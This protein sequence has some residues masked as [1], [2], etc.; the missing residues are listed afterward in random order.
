MTSAVDPMTPLRGAARYTGSRVARV[1]DARLL[2]G[3]GVFVDDVVLQGMLHCCFVRSP[4]ARARIVG[5]DVSEAQALPG[6]HAVFVGADLNSMSVLPQPEPTSLYF[7]VDVPWAPL[8]EDCARFVGDPVALVVAQDRYVAEDASDLVVV[9]YEPLPA[10]VDYGEAENTDILVHESIGTNSSGEFG[11]GMDE[12]ETVLSASDHV[13]EHTIHQQAYAAV[14]METRGIVVDYS[15]STGEMTVYAA[16]QSPHEMRA[17]CSR[18]LGMPQHRIRVIMKDT[19]GGFGQKIYAQREE[20]VVILAARKLGTPLKWIEDRQENLISGGKSRIEHGTVRLAFDG[21]GT[22]QGVQLD[23]VSDSGA[24]PRP[25]PMSTV[26]LTGPMFP[27]P[28]RVPAAGFRCRTV[29][30]NTVPRTPYRGPWQFETLARE[31]SYDIAARQLGIDPIELR[32]RNL[33]SRDDMPYANP[34][35]MAYD[36][37]SPLETFEHGLEI[38][39]YEAFRREQA[40]ARAAGRFIGV[41]IGNYVEP[42]TPG[43]GSHGTEGATIRI[44]PTGE[45]NV[46]IAGGSSGNSVETTV[47]QLTAD[48]LGVDIADVNTIQGDTAVTGFGAG[49]G[50]SRTGSMIAGAIGTTASLLRD[51]M[52]AIAAHQLEASIDDIEL[53]DG[54]ASVRGTP[55][56]GMTVREIAEVSYNVSILPP[57]I[58]AGLEV[59]ARYASTVAPFIFVN[60]THICT[61]EVDIETGFVRLLRYI[62]SEDCGPMINPN[63]VEGQIAGGTVQGIGGVLLEHL[64]YDDAGNPVSAT[65]MDYLLPTASDVPMIEHGHVETP[66]R[67]PGGYKGVGEGGAI[68]S[69]PAVVNA[70][71]DALAPFGVVISHLPLGPSQ[72]LRLLEEARSLAS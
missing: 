1:E 24:Y 59:S 50:G 42:T 56:I 69:P 44:E 32:R 26:G 52:K 22:V 30:S 29:Y 72:I 58:P 5:I 37:I 9:E 45:V 61:C 3:R 28:Y 27:G 68:G 23:L 4:H 16:S 20:S 40:E 54:R 63:V 31:V 11:V 62:V 70:I 8:T 6:V 57:D 39:D 55:S 34:C 25:S 38:L 51:R 66:S 18:M 43:M 48:A 7:L 14:P 46:Y 13:V 49:T 21:G 71:A 17:F 15:P 33:L 53:V 65:F 47:V 12:I 60:A 35:G 19:G 41:G 64:A 10:L 2:T 36:A 67:G